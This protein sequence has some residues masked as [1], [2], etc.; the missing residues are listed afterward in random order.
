MKAL[1]RIAILV[2]AISLAF[3]LVGC[4]RND[5]TPDTAADCSAGHTY[6]NACDRICNLCGERRQ[7]EHVYDSSCDTECNICGIPHTPVHE[8]DNACDAECNNCGASRT[9]QHSF[10]NEWCDSTCNNC[11]YVR[12][13]PHVF[14]NACD[15]KCNECT[16]TREVKGHVYTDECDADCNECGRTRDEVPHKDAD[17]NGKCDLCGEVLYVV[18]PGDRFDLPE[19]PIYDG[20]SSYVH[21]NGG[22]PYFL[23]TQITNESFESYSDF[24][25][26]GRCGVAFACLGRDTLPTESRDFSL[27]GVSPTGWQGNSIYERSHL[28]AW[29]LSAETTNKKNLITGT[30]TLNGVMQDFENMVCDYIKETGNHVMYR[31]T[32][33]FE[34]DNL[35]ASG[36]LLEAYSVEDEGEGIEFCIYIYN[37]QKDYEIDYKTGKATLDSDSDVSRA[38]FVFNKSKKKIHIATCTSVASMNESNALLWYDSYASFVEYLLTN[39]YITS[40]SQSGLN[41]GNCK[42]QNVKRQVLFTIPEKLF[43]TVTPTEKKRAA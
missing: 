38:T 2:L 43:Y 5:N 21:I 15:A 35:L 31:S 26:L 1:T 16:F 11:D 18:T 33:V 14:D 27:S 28:I 41:C 13:A 12:T 30:F 4:K 37:V 25:T 24:D 7:I 8:Y 39:N 6:D 34:G 20:K 19:L 32:P 17:S 42:P 3:A 36:L 23:P 10:D 29:S 9:P 22:K 40:A